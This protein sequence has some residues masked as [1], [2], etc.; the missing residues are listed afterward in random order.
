MCNLVLKE[1]KKETEE[2]YVFYTLLREEK[3]NDSCRHLPEKYVINR[4]NNAGGS[5]DQV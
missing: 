2:N 5:R 3:I 4:P 1:G